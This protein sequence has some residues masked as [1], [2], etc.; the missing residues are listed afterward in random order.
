MRLDHL[1]SKSSEQLSGILV[2]RIEAPLTNSSLSGDETPGSKPLSI[3]SQLL[4][5]VLAGL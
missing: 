3:T 1:L 5:P 4:R 2:M